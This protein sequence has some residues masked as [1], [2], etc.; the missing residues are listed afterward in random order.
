MLRLTRALVTT[1]VFLSSSCHT[2]MVL[3][4]PAEMAEA[5]PGLLQ[6]CP[7]PLGQAMC[8]RA[9]RICLFQ[10]VPGL[11]QSLRA[12]REA[13]LL[14]RSA[15]TITARPKKDRKKPLAGQSQP[16][17][18]RLIQAGGMAA[19]PHSNKLLFKMLKKEKKCLS[20][21][22]PSS[23]SLPCAAYER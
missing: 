6:R 12:H 15:P 8:L 23:P 10:G 21:L 9:A 2:D 22:L 1:S 13:A 5:Q 16:F 18:P 3:S 19:Q 17:P 4:C 11:H 20:S 14:V 7:P